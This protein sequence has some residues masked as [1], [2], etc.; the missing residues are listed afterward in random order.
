MVKKVRKPVVAGYFYERDRDKL[1][2]QIKWSIEHDL[3]PKE[4]VKKPREG[5]NAV[6]IGISPHA[7]Y[8][9][10]GPIAAH[11][12]AEIYRFHEPKTF[13]IAGPNH[14]GFGPPV[15]IVDEGVWETPLGSVEIDSD[16]ARELRK[17]CNVVEIDYFAH[18]REHSIEV[19]LPFIQY[20]FKDFKIVP[21]T[22]LIQDLSIAKCL[23]KAIA[24]IIRERNLGEVIYIA[25]TDWNHYEPHEVTVEKDM[26]AIEKVLNLDVDGFYDIIRRLDIS[27]C[28][29]GAVGTAIVAAREINVKDVKLLKHATSGDTSGYFLETV[30][31]AAIAFYV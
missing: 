22:L 17:K 8:V 10:S 14:H 28:G 9:Y 31:Y 25:S 5:Y 18:E 4:V 12:F 7:G 15:A 23:G 19:Q 20:F 13:I 24:E 26:K 6:P 21:I 1:V 27:V 29:Y 2:Q 3:G 30:G 16:I 11:I